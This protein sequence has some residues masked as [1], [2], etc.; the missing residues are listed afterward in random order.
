MSNLHFI[1]LSSETTPIVTDVNLKNDW[2]DF[3]KK[4]DYYNYLNTVSRQNSCL[5]TYRHYSQRYK[6]GMYICNLCGAI[7]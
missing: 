3:G 4:N 5:V 2:V 6:C 1:Q 7:V